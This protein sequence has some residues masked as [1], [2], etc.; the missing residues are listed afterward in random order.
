MV[1]PGPP[2]QSELLKQGLLELLLLQLNI[3]ID[4]ISKTFCEKED[5]IFSARPLIATI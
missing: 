5:R 2:G 3:P 4:K 1:C